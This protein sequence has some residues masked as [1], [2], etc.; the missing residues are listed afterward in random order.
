MYMEREWRCINF[1]VLVQVVVVGG[2][3]IAAVDMKAVEMA[4]GRD[5]MVVSR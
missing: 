4:T 1:G 3:M 2:S 5:M